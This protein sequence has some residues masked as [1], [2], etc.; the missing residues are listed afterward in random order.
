[1]QWTL[2]CAF[3]EP[4]VVVKQKVEFHVYGNGLPVWLPKLVISSSVYSAREMGKMYGRE[5]GILVNKDAA[6]P[7]QDLCT[8]YQD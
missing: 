5:E 3:Y 1:M 2:Q 7:S 4:K 6:P 8:S